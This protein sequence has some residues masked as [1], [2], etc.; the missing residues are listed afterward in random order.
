[1]IFN[2]SAPACAESR[3]LHRM[4]ERGSETAVESGNREGVLAHTRHD[5]GS[6]ARHILMLDIIGAAGDVIHSPISLVQDV[7]NGV[8]KT[9][10]R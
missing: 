4:S 9:L 7:G 2:F 6:L 8:S 1:M 5:L 10:D 3:L